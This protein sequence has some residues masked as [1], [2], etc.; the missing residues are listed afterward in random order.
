METAV[1]RFWKY[2]SKGD[3]CWEWSGPITQYGYGRLNYCK[4]E[5]L[6]HR[7]SWE[8]HCGPIPK[9]NVV[10]GIFVCHHCDNRKCVNPKHLFLGTIQDNGADMVNKKRNP[11]GTKHGMSKLTPEKVRMIRNLYAR[12]MSQ[13]KIGSLVGISQTNASCILTG[14]TWGHIS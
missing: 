9:K 3:S 4:K 11:F 8:I 7:F 13:T 1:D 6:A 2:V 14:K 10:R 5:K 12:G